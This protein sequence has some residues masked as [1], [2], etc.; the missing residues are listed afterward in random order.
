MDCSQATW[1]IH[2]PAAESAMDNSEKRWLSD[3][4]GLLLLILPKM[5]D[6]I[7]LARFAVYAA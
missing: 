1:H 6:G 7:D 4:F 3:D 2:G 5:M